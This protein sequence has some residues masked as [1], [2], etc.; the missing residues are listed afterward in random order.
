MP[1]PPVNNTSRASVS[2]V[3]LSSSASICAG[4]SFTM[5]RNTTAW[6]AV[7]MRFS[8]RSPP[9]SFSRV[10]V[11]LTVMMATFTGPC[12][13]AIWRCCSVDWLLMPAIVSKAFH[14]KNTKN[15][16]LS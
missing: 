11:S 7:T 16:K 15:T 4:S 8:I 6:P 1:V 5:A 14:T 10:R 13:A 12:F 3:I 2:P 9:V